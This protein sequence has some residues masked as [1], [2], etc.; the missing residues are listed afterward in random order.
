MNFSHLPSSGSRS[1]EPMLQ[2][3]CGTTKGTGEP[4]GRAELNAP[5]AV[6]GG[7]GGRLSSLSA[8][9]QCQCPSTGKARQ[10]PRAA[11]N[12]P[13]PTKCAQPN[14]A[15]SPNIYLFK[16]NTSVGWFWWLRPRCNPGTQPP[17]PTS[18]LPPALQIL[19]PK[20][21]LGWLFGGFLVCRRPFGVLSGIIHVDAT[22]LPSSSSFL[23]PK[24]TASVTSSHA[25]RPNS[26]LWPCKSKAATQLGRRAPL[27]SPN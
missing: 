14:R 24:S 15:F 9:R 11:H 26:S 16:L 22:V 20:H 8:Q 13:I 3:W 1:Q 21:N 18:P 6:R 23:S 2:R 12:L 17:P 5:A 27:F 19:F 10:Q 4:V 7:R 25:D